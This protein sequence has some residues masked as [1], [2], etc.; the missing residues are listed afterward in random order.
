MDAAL[1]EYGEKDAAK[2]SEMDAVSKARVDYNSR[3]LNLPLYKDFFDQNDYPPELNEKL[4]DLILEKNNIVF[5]HMQNAPKDWENPKDYSKNIE[6]NQQ[7]ETIKAQYDEKIAE[8][9]PEGGLALFKEY[10]KR[11]MERAL[12]F[13]LEIMLGD[14]P[15]EKE[16][17]RELIELLYEDTQTYTTYAEVLKNIPGAAADVVPEKKID[18][19]TEDRL[20]MESVESDIKKYAA[21]I[22]SAE[23]VLSESQMV[24]FEGMINSFRSYLLQDNT[25]VNSNEIEKDKE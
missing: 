13:N 20:F 22:E 8:L 9:L 14:D 5:Q 19:E 12:V 10:E 15:L 18:E 4:V 7:T 3:R 2:A 21:Y 16:K 17:E 11:S 6:F 1:N 23:D 25:T 24:K